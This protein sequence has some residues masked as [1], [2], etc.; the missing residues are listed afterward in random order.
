[1]TY[2]LKEFRIVDTRISALLRDNKIIQKEL[3]SQKT[4][5]RK[6]STRIKQGIRKAFAKR[7]NRSGRELAGDG[8][9]GPSAVLGPAE[10]E[11][12]KNLE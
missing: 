5:L 6:L 8:D 7:N 12:L 4:G 10:P 3:I 1:M 11:K 9:E 2:S